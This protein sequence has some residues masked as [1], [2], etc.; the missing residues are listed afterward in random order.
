MLKNKVSHKVISFVMLLIIGVEMLAPSA[1]DITAEIGLGQLY[2]ACPNPTREVRRAAPR[3]VDCPPRRAATMHLEPRRVLPQAIREEPYRTMVLEMGRYFNNPFDKSKDLGKS[4][5]P[6][7]HRTAFRGKPYVR[8][9]LIYLQVYDQ[10]YFTIPHANGTDQY[11][12]CTLC[13]FYTY[14]R[15]DIPKLHQICPRHISELREQELKPTPLFAHML[16]IKENLF[17]TTAD[18][19]D[20]C[21]GCDTQLPLNASLWLSQKT[22]QQGNAIFGVCQTLYITVLLGVMAFLF[23]RDM[24]N[25][26]IRPIESMVDS[27]TRLAANPAH[28]LEAV[29]SVKYETDALRVSLNKIA[30]LLQVGFGEAGNNLV[31]EN[32][33]KGDTVDPMVPGKKLLGAYGFCIIDDY[34]EVLECLGEEILP[35]TNMA[36]RVLHDAVTHNGGQPNRNLGDAFLCV[37]KPQMLEGNSTQAEL[38]LAEQK[39]CDGALT[40]FRRAVRE[41]SRSAKLQAYNKNEEIIKY[42]DGEYRT[43]MGYG[44]NYGYAIEGAVGTNIKIDCSYLSPNVNLA[45]RLES[46][47]KRYGVNI[48]MS[49]YF[50]DKLSPAVKQGVRRV[51]VVCLK[52]SSIPM[53]IYTCD[54]SNALYVEQSAIDKYGEENVIG[55]FQRIFEEGV[56]NFVQGDWAEGKKCF[57]MC[58]TICPRDK[59]ARRLLMHMDT[60]ENHPDF[61][62]ASEGQPYVAPEGWPGYHFLLSK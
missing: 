42:F 39:M 5:S 17:A 38:K 48:L 57:E 50:Y 23:S 3:L 56:D 14:A 25:L 55:E 62:L 24:D 2:F 4:S 41:I 35:F 11:P 29:K 20:S 31:A 59:P 45:A 30:Q 36:A 8:D 53:S 28:K 13:N 9:N 58:L 61:G 43:V 22:F 1:T 32:L 34:E 51:D 7:Q 6:I 44:L 33:K 12:D 26:V 60:A 52:G 15:L 54:R 47:T 40:A 19:F 37:W 46:A 16:M 21:D 10:V 18:T 27:V 49:Q